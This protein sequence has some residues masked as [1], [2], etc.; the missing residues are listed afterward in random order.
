[1]IMIIF[2]YIFRT[3]TT[4]KTSSF[5]PICTAICDFHINFLNF[6]CVILLIYSWVAFT[7]TK[8]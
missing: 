7:I 1:M 8:E 4:Q 2:I 5:K 6:L 3:N